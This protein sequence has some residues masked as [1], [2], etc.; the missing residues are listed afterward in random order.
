M[1]KSKY[2]GKIYAGNWLCTSVYLAANYCSGTKHNA[3]RYKLTRITSDKKCN[4]II[5]VSGPT[6]KKIA[7]GLT[8]P[9]QVVLNKKKTKLQINEISYTFLD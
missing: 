4:K 9:D 1:K 5:S 8:T 7:L 2:L 6:M 3:Y